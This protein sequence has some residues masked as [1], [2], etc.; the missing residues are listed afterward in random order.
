[1][2]SINQQQPEQNHADLQGADALHK[3]KEIV[4]QSPNCFFCTSQATGE[5]RGVRPMNVRQVDAHGRLWFLSASD[6]HQNREIELDP[7]VQLFFQGSKH[8]DFLHLTG[9]AEITRD[10]AKVHELWEPM[11]KTW[12]TQGEDDPRITI[13]KFSPSEGYYWDTKHGSV[14]AFAKIM[15]GA[16]IGKT[17][18]DSIEGK[19]T[20]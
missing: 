13:I 18:D 20:V 11:I 8:S 16:V 9:R 12:F 7:S 3:I 4:S 15:L 19:L 5:T 1:M 6:S 2:N 17:L 10:R 14:I